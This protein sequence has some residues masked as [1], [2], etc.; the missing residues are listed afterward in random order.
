MPEI[1]ARTAARL[2]AEVLLEPGYG[3]VGLIRFPNGRKSFFWD[4]KFNLNPIS[5]V[6]ICQD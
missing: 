2:G 1:L 4:N 5:S 3:F 6:K